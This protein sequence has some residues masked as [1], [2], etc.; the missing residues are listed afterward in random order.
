MPS[1]FVSYSRQDMIAVQTLEQALTANGIAVWRD[2]D[3]ICGGEQWPKA[4]AEAVTAYRQ[5]LQVRTPETLPL[6]WAQTQNNLARA[7][8]YL[9]DWPNAAASY[10]HVL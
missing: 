10:T 8:E 7:Y 1:I 3:S 2:Q 9:E 5:A 4:I 6:Q